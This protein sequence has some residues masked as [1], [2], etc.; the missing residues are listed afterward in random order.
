M[1]LIFKMT[2]IMISSSTLPTPTSSASS[3]ISSTSASSYPSFLP[4]DQR[5]NSELKWEPLR[6]ADKVKY[7]QIIIETIDVVL[8][9]LMEQAV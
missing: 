5:A 2:S 9:K 6:R 7:S 4:G 8:K 1:M 3:T